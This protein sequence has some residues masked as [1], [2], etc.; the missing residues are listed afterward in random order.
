MHRSK[1]IRNKKNNSTKRKRKRSLICIRT[2][3][4]SSRK[5]RRSNAIPKQRK[6]NRKRRKQKHFKRKITRIPNGFFRSK[7][8]RKRK[9]SIR[10]ISSRKPQLST[11]TEHQ[12]QE[13]QCLQEDY[14]ASY[15]N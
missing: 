5:L 3:N 2:R 7:R 10:N 9:K 11:N 12:D 6:R 8:T 13:K 4:N 14:Q 15:Q 1:K